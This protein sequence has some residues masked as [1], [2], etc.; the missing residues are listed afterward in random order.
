MPIGNK[1]HT[2]TCVFLNQIAIDKESIDCNYKTQ[3]IDFI[4]SED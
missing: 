4:F 3:S 1:V 2:H